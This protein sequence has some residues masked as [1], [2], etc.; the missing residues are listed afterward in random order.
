[1]TAEPMARVPELVRRNISLA[2]DLSCCTNVVFLPDQPLYVL[3]KMFTHT[4]LCRYC[5]WITV[6][7]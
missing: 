7:T 4:W 1:M 5:I 2:R 6:T 3:K